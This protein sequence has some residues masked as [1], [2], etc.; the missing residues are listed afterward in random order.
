[1]GYRQT[2]LTSCAAVALVSAACHDRI[3]FSGPLSVLADSLNRRVDFACNDVPSNVMK[4]APHPARICEAVAHDTGVTVLVADDGTVLGITRE[5]KESNG[6]PGV[7]WR[8]L[9]RM[10]DRQ[11]G[12]VIPNCGLTSSARMRVW[13]REGYNE[14][15]T[16]DTLRDEVRLT[17]TRSEPPPCKSLD[18]AVTPQTRAMTLREQVTTELVPIVPGIKIAISSGGKA[19]G[20]ALMVRRWFALIATRTSAV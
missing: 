1:M 17:Q 12:A 6:V 16:V 20:Y 4:Q 11:T 9:E 5:W 13:R 15:L 10:L 18:S 8:D 14:V 2:L 7:T 3:S 19:F